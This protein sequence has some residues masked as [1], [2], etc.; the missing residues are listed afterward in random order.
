[1]VMP[2]SVHEAVLADTCKK[3]EN[4]DGERLSATVHIP[5]VDCAPHARCIMAGDF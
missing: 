4:D 5:S 3:K 1:M 2:T